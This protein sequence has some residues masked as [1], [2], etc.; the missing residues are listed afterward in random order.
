METSSQSN[1][2]DPHR[3]EPLPGMLNVLTILTF[4]GCGLAY[5]LSLLGYFLTGNASES[6]QKMSEAGASQDQIDLFLKSAEHRE[7]I[8]ITSLVFTTLCL[9]GAIQMRKRKKSGYFL[10]VIGEIAP[11]VLQ[12]GLFGTM[13][14][15]GAGPFAAIGT[16][17]GLA[18]PIVFVILYSTQLK[19]L[20]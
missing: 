20:K 3:P 18:V 2:L 16:V 9:V 1:I 15:G 5:I 17:I 19:Y 11:I 7:L 12:F 13:S 6:V 10:Y 8:L 4:I 14:S